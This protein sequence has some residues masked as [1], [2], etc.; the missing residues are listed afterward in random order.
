MVPVASSLSKLKT[1]LSIDCACTTG[2]ETVLYQI[3]DN[4][5]GCMMKS[6]IEQYLQCKLLIRNEQWIS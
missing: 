3:C 1:W 2:E 4:Y 6:Q 5:V